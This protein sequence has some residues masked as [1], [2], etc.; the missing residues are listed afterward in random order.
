MNAMKELWTYFNEIMKL[1]YIKAL[2]SWDQQVSMPKGSVKRRAEQLAL[3]QNLIHTRIK[4]NK[5]GELIRNAEIISNL[6][7]TDLA[8]IREAKREYEQAIRIPDDLIT[9]VTK[10]ASLGY[11]EWEK[12]RK[13]S[14]FSIFQPYLEKMI[15]LQIEYAEKL[16]TGPTLYSNLIDLYE[17]GATYEW[18]SKIF[19]DLKPKLIKIVDKLSKSSN[20]PD[21][22]ILK[23]HF[24]PEKQWQLSLDIIK[25][26]NFDF[27]TGRQDKSTHPFTIS[28]SSIDTRITTRIRE[29]FLIDCLFSTIHECGHALYY[30]GFKEEIH[31]S[32]LAGSCSYGIGESQ[33]RTWE[34]LIGRS[35][36]FWMYW[37]PIFQ[38]AF[39]E[40]LKNY[41]ME[42]F[43]R[44]INVVQ[45]SFI[46]VDADEVTYGLHVILRFEI[47][48]MIIEENLQ[49]NE[50][51]AV[52][53]EEMEGLLGI[54]PPIDALGVLQDAHWS[55]GGFGYFPTYVLGNLYATQIYNKALKIYPSLLED[56]K[57]G[58]FSNIL[59][60][61]RK[62]IY[63]YGKIFRARDLIKRITGEDLNPDY[64]IKYIEDKFYPI[65]G[66]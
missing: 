49:V 2:L 11:I 18:I 34:N 24:D 28:L 40:N 12:A 7:E 64:F 48:K 33:S 29:N 66:F 6:N 46:R 4:S 57:K 53:N 14:D 21:Q 19:K 25:K 63:Q 20:K 41:P 54:N 65:Y 61:L 1:N 17:P 15:K 42:E 31:D 58:E 13:K 56:Y 38:N 23:K 45:P 22:S 59:N 50:L 26:L 55:S 8:L 10:T 62:E 16:D 44:S 43:Y 30:M 60:Y 51:P 3:M 35:K 27:N 52:W 32:L 36:E 5:T 39:P 9:E 47:E 37:Y